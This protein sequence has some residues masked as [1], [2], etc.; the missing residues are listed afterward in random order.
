MLSTTRTR[1]CRAASAKVRPSSTAGGDMGSDRNLSMRPLCRSSARPT[2]LDAAANATVCPKMPG[3]R[4]S[5]IGVRTRIARNGDG[6]A[7]DVREQQDEDHRLHEREE[8]Q[9]GDPHGLDEV[10]TRDDESVVAAS[11]P[12]GVACASGACC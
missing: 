7:E 3:M 2:V 11:T 1:T 10:A 6:A 8:Q 5:P 4:Y 12:T 9:L